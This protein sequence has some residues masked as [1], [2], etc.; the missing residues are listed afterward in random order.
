M[1]LVTNAR[2]LDS[3]FSSLIGGLLIGALLQPILSQLLQKS[4]WISQTGSWS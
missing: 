4:G 3:L 2:P 1:Y